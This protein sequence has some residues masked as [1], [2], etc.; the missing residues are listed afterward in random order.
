MQDSQG[1]AVHPDLHVEPTDVVVRCGLSPLTDSYSAFRDN[2]RSTVSPLL[3]IL[4][5]EGIQELYCCGLATEFCLLFTALDA[6]ILLEKS[7]EVFVLQDCCRGITED[8]V[9]GAKE[10]LALEQVALVRAADDDPVFGRIPRRDVVGGDGG[11]G[12]A[13]AGGGRALATLA[14]EEDGDED[15]A[16]PAAP[17]RPSA[18][19]GDAAGSAGPS[20]AAGAAALRRRNQSKAR[21]QQDL[22]DTLHQGAASGPAGPLDMLADEDLA[23]EAVR[24]VWT[25]DVGRVKEVLAAGADPCLRASW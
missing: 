12:D 1:A 14:E 9:A 8:G 19:P 18:G 21:R 5:A 20:A 7:C 16:A 13:A 3:E 2:D 22:S 17:T 23:L 4:K 25:A 6:R 24:A 11:G 15:D 10:K